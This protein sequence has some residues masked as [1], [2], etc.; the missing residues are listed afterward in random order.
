V[1]L[2]QEKY[3]QLFP[4]QQLT[5]PISLRSHHFQ[6]GHRRIYTT[7]ETKL[8]LIILFWWINA[9]KQKSLRRKHHSPMDWPPSWLTVKMVASQSGED[10]GGTG[11]DLIL[12]TTFAQR[13]GEKPWKVSQ[14]SQNLRWDSTRTNPGY[15]PEALLQ[16]I[17]HFQKGSQHQG[18]QVGCKT[19]HLSHMWIC[20]RK[21]SNM[22]LFPSALQLSLASYSTNA[23]HGFIA[24]AQYN[25]LQSHQTSI[26]QRNKPAGNCCDG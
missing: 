6:K 10:V 11:H 1:C 18:T 16:Y 13:D 9:S 14:D 26:I 8:Q 17:S 19:V 25:T 21:S 3:I 23:A 22:T 24:R 12:K 2:A 20:G 15:K 5:I 7:I 4:L